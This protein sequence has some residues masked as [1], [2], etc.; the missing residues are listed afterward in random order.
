[1]LLLAHCHEVIEK[2]RLG[3]LLL[4]SASYATK[5]AAVAA[6]NIVLVEQAPAAVVAQWNMDNT[7]GTEMEDSSGNGNNGTTY[8]VV[9]SDAGY[10]FNGSTSKVVVPDSSTLDPGTSDF[11]YSV[12]VWTDRV[13]PEGGDYDILR[14]GTSIRT[15]GEYKLEIKYSHGLGKALCVVEDGLGNIASVRGTTNVADGNLHTLTCTK[16]SHSLALQVDSLAPQTVT[17]SVPGPINN[18]KALTLGVKSETS[19]GS[20]GD[21]FYGTMRSGTVSVGP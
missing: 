11:S 16:T 21:W 2:F 13:P 5:M 12:Q 18:A 17:A 7:F 9:T 6:L 8:D 3:E 1:M 15:G 20:D 4:M 10:M 19:T 14:K